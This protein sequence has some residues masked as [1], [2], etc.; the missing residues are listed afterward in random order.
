MNNK[1]I[2]T[3]FNGMTSEIHEWDCLNFTVAYTDEFRKKE[4]EK[5][6]IRSYI[7]A[8]YR[9]YD[10]LKIENHPTD[11][12]TIFK[13]ND[14]CYPFLFMCR[15]SIELSLKF[16]LENNKNNKDKGSKVI[17]GHN[18]KKLWDKLDLNKYYENDEY[19]QLINLFEV[20]D[21]DG[22][23]L[24]YIKDK[25]GKENFKQLYFIKSDLI[26]QTTI[27]LCNELLNDSE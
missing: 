1:F 5:T 14:L 24:R 20:L 12:I 15:H 2:R 19:N 21:D 25:G 16:L 18:L 26:L 10:N 11:G 8:M 22:T 9:L 13:D 7:N 23:K 4:S 3:Q 17:S 27:N 6:I